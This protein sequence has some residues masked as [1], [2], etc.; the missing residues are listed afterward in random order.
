MKSKATLLLLWLLTVACSTQ[1]KL[2]SIKESQLSSSLSLIGEYELPELEYKEESGDTLTVMNEEG[3]EV[4]IMKASLDEN[5]E[6][7]ANDVIKAAKVTARFRNV[8]ERQGKVN[9]SFDVTI[10]WEIQ[11]SKWQLRFYPDLIILGD[12]LRLEPIIITGNDYRKAQL[13]GYQLYE[14]FLS[15]IITDSSRFYMAHQLEM[16]LKRNLPGIYNFR[17]DS[18]FVADSVF[19][20]YYGVTEKEAVDHYTKWLIVRHNEKKNSRIDRMYEKYVKVPIVTEGLRLDSVIVNTDK[21]IV[22]RYTQTINARPDLKK[23][24]VVLSGEIYDQDDKLLDLPDS[25][26]LTFYIS[27]LSSLV[28]DEK[29]YLTRITERRVEANASCNIDFPKGESRVD[30]KFGRN[31]EEIAR[32]KEYLLSLME[33]RDFDLDSII[34]SASCSPEGSSE[35]NKRL[36]LNRSEAVSEYFGYIMTELTDSVEKRQGILLNMG[37]VEIVKRQAKD[38]KF[39]ARSDGENW[40][41][42]QTIVRND[43]VLSAEQKRIFEEIMA[44]DNVDMR[45]KMMSERDFYGHIFDNIFP[46]LRTVRFD[47]HLHR[48]GMVKDT[49]H[50]TVVDSTYMEGVQAI[51]DMDY[52]KAVTILRPYMDYNTAVAYCAMDYNASVIAILENLEKSDKTEYL[53]AIIYSRNGDSQKAVQ[54]YMNACSMNKSFINRG[55]LDPEISGLI[56]TY[57]LNKDQ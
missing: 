52:A 29:R 47:F 3:K 30:T 41:M 9:L 34:V 25:E 19:E 1:Q 27:S 49:I 39:I 2:N 18:S 48:K 42:L 4:L 14:R 20:S 45:E 44:V 56:R 11:D 22:Y 7:V 26:P 31:E 37:S 13:R 36:S 28:D 17:K 38:I 51:K 50:T 16:F 33:N 40:E 46:R 8:A 53:K 23:A 5:G 54:C 43:T 35:L 24:D 57:N 12:S 21:D 15:S 55:N 6:M 10:P 32:I